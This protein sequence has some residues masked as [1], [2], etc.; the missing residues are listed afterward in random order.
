MVF[1]SPSMLIS[2]IFYLPFAFAF[3]IIII[4]R[5]QDVGNCLRD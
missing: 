4:E 2:Y 1:L 3:I 5:A